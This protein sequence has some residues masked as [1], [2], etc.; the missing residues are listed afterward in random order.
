MITG[1]PITNV[2]EYIDRF[3]KTTQKLLKQLRATIKKAA[4]GA[5]EII[6][7]QMPAYKHNGR[8]LYFA[9]YNHHVGFYPMASG[10][11]RF[12]K[13]IAGYKNAKGSVQ[14][15]LD[16]PLPVDLVTKMVSFRVKE[17]LEKTELKLKKKK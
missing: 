3:P 9:G 14:F 12:K 17:N 1:T 10:I 15:P 8:L 11:A 16:Q 7:Y 13:E 4:P 5:E 2:D 6:S